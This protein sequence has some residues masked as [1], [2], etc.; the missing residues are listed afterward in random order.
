MEIVGEICDTLK[1]GRGLVAFSK[2]VGDG[3]IMK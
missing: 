1:G 2:S 3:L